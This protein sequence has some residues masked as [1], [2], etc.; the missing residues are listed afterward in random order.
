M[1]NEI[2]YYFHDWA[3]IGYLRSTSVLRA[4]LLAAGLTPIALCPEAAK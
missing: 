1:K 4:F 2:L 3:L